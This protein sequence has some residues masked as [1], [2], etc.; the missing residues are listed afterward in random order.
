MTCIYSARAREDVVKLDTNARQ[1]MMRLRHIAL[2]S[3][4]QLCSHVLFEIQRDV[5]SDEKLHL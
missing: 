4:W 2:V 1:K 5:S 3:L